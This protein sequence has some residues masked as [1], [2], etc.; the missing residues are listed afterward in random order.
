[1]TD[2][3]EALREALIELKL[4]RER[5]AAALRESNALL[6]GLSGMNAAETPDEAVPQLLGAI[7]ASLGCDAV[8]LLSGPRGR[9]A[10]SHATDPALIGVA[11]GDAP[12]ARTR[13]MRVADTRRVDAWQ[14]LAVPL[15]DYRAVLSVPIA[16]PD[17]R[18]SAIVCFSRAPAAFTSGD[19]RLLRRLSVLA[20]QGL[21]TLRLAERNALLAGVIDGSSASVAI[22]DATREELPL[23][24]VNDAFLALSGYARDEVLGANCRFL[25]AE[26]ADSRERTRLR[27]A[28]RARGS[29]TFTLLNRRRDGTL[30]WNRLTLFAV[31]DRGGRATHLVATQTD[32]TAER[33]AAAERDTAR[34]RLISALSATSEG[35]IV[36]DP[37]G[38]VVF[39][40]PAYRDFFDETGGLFTDGTRFVDAW[41]RRLMAL[42]LGQPTA[43]TQARARLNALFGGAE[44]REEALPDGR[45]LLVND[46]PTDDGGAVS[47][48]TDITALKVTERVLA[49]RAAAID[50]TQD[51]IAVTD[52]D[53]RFVYMN[54]AHLAMFGYEA[55]T[56]VLGRPWGILYA[57][58]DAERIERE[59]MPMLLASGRWRGEIPGRTKTGAVVEQEASLTFLQGIGIVCVTRDVGE[60][61]RAERERERLGDQ[62]QTAQRREAIGQ[63]AAGVAHDFNNLLSV[64]GTSTAL[65][66]P[67]LSQ[68]PGKAGHIARIGAAAERAAALVRR[69]MDLAGK[70]TET[71][72]IDMRTVLREASDLLRA[73]MPGSVSMT[74]EMPDTAVEVDADPTEMLQV[75]LNLGINARDALG[76]GGGGV[77]LRLCPP[78]DGEGRSGAAADPLIGIVQAGTRYAAI[79]VA[80]TGKGMGEGERQRIFEPYYTTKGSEGTGLGLVV[81]SSVV[82][83]VGGAVDVVSAPGRGSTFRIYWPLD[84]A[85]VAHPPDG[86]ET[87]AVDLHGMLVLVCDDLPDVGRSIAALL[88]QA[89]AE[90]AVCEDPRDA[91]DAVTEDPGSWGLVIT[92][93]DMPGMTGAELA[94]AVRRLAPAMPI[95]L[96]SALAEAQRHAA[97]ADAVLA[98]PVTPARLQA[99]VARAIFA[100]GRDASARDASAR[101]ALRHPVGAVER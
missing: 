44:D 54:P 16:M 40:N 31:R 29:G 10:I 25:S 61:R 92:D 30:F 37:A 24:Y 41:A 56:E 8:V 87:I 27:D 77:A 45:I 84:H 65:L 76:P 2:K 48:A 50:A 86:E 21:E 75:I 74:V 3:D 58:E 60:R 80:D 85:A 34:R 88:E 42:G 51:G 23:V 64:I 39:A 69:L 4:L 62:L 73:G 7:R 43:R 53:G 99:A 47:I 18:L 36:L 67:D 57:P 97:R 14:G 28:I 17:E 52:E 93:Y 59:G 72:R 38:A 33:A 78:C 63:L 9:G 13:P 79:E 98:K 1:M 91:L 5:E 32:I 19:Q 68:D 101:G 96:C 81:V 20:A 71:R 49:Q 94:E 89:G 55:E 11:M 82:A 22:A 90:V 46:R 26:D 66:E 15:S 100:R 6:E 12:G 83:K 95:V 35:F 70:S